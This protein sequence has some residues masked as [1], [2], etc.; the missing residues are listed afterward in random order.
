MKKKAH[1]GQ[2][3]DQLFATPHA[4]IEEFAFNEQVARVFDDMID[5][6]VPGYRTVIALSAL[7]AAQYA[8]PGSNCYDLGCSLGATTLAMRHRIPH[9]TCRIVAVD[10]AP[11]M[12]ERFHHLLEQDDG[13]IP[14]EIVLDDMVRV[15]L[16]QASVVV[17]NFTLQFLNLDQRYPLLE[18]I[19]QGLNPGGALVISEKTFELD[20][21]HQQQLDEWHIA[22][23]RANGYSDLEIS[24]KRTALENVLIPETSATHLQR[25]RDVGFGAP[26]QWFQCF[27]FSS[28]VAVK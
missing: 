5:R 1:F 3:P 16:V 21:S 13:P 20:R 19:Y 23:K 17:L 8:Q 25:L 14:V 18:R 2:N 11:A 26:R 6:S 4:R 27:N 28:F 7:L 10:N 22:F 9:T 12:L 24:Q 15:P